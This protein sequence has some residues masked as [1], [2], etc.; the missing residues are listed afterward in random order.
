MPKMPHWVALNEKETTK[1]LG[2]TASS[3]HCQTAVRGG[4]IRAFA[5]IPS[6][7]LCAFPPSES[8]VNTNGRLQRHL[9]VK[10]DAMLG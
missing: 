1:M 4:Q 10:Y 7:T 3:L 5:G 6:T 2:K 9:F 8:L